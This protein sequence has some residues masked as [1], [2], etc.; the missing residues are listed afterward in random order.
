MLVLSRKVNEEIVIDGDIRVTVLEIQGNRVR[1][2]IAA[3]EQV[4][5]RR[6]EIAFGIDAGLT[7]RMPLRSRQ[8]QSMKPRDSGDARI[9]SRGLPEPAVPARSR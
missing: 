7:G 5:I 3:P 4:A 9:V 6:G 1:L 2:G 8:G